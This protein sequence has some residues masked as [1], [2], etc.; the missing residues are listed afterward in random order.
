[1][2]ACLHSRTA[3]R[4]LLELARFPAPSAEALYQGARAVAWQEW[5]TV[6]TTLAV[7]ATVG[8]LGHHPLRLRRPQGEGRGGGR[9]CATRWAP[10]PT[11]TPRT[12]TSGSC[13]TSHAGPGR[14]LAR[15]GRRAA[16]PARLPR[17]HHRGAAQGDAGGGGAAPRRRRPERSRSSTPWPAPGR[18]P[19]STRCGPAASPPGSSR[20]FGFQRWPSYRGGP[21]SAWDRIKEEA[22]AA[23][24]P[25]RPA[26]IL[27]RDGHPKAIEALRGTRHAA[28]V[29]G[30][31]EIEK[32]DA[33]DL[34]PIAAEGTLVTNPPYGE[35][36]GGKGGRRAIG[37]SGATEGSPRGRGDRPGARSRPARRARRGA[38]GHKKLAGFYRGLAEMLERHRGWTAV[39]LSGNPLLPA[40]HPP[41]ARGGPPA[42]E[43]AAGDPP[44]QVPDPVSGP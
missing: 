28:G 1:M 23:A 6:R 3:M 16:P 10:G 38:G 40:G 32:A 2:R 19:S 26:P 35:R 9:H 22:R 27:A 7:E 13:S 20:A 31:L 17:R 42:L 24:L 25:T 44:A 36:L 5:L 33:R 12:R 37:V 18:W 29:L 39:L 41:A 34:E 30:D 4:V 15:P 8:V 11:S 43:R 21:Q 14:P